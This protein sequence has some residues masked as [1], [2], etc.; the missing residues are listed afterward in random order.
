[1]LW[2]K[3]LKEESI[4]QQCHEDLEEELREDGWISDEMR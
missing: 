3:D 4:C 2:N 1:M